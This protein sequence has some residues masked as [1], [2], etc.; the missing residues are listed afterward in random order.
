M[1]MGGLMSWTVETRM[2]DFDQKIVVVLPQEYHEG[3]EGV[4]TLGL[5][6]TSAVPE[7]PYEELLSLV[8]NTPETRSWVLMTDY[9]LIRELF[10]VDLPGPE[11]D[12]DQLKEFLIALSEA[13]DNAMPQG[14]FISGFKS[15]FETVSRDYLGF[16]VRNV[17]QSVEAGQPPGV[18][19]AVR[20]RFDPEGTDRALR[21]CAECPPPDRTSHLG[22]AFYSWG[23]DYHV[24]LRR[25][26]EPPAF[27]R[28]GRGGRIAVQEGYV[29][30]TLATDDMK[31]LI[32]ASLGRWRSLGDL[33]ELRL[34]ARA[35]ASLG[36][37]STLLTDLT[38]RLEEAATMGL[39][40]EALRSLRESPS[41]RP[42]LAFATGVGQDAGG[43]YMALA[44]VHVDAASAEQNVGLLRRRIEEAT[45]LRFPGTPWAEIFDADSLEV[46]SDGR[47]LVAKLRRT[48]GRMGTSWLQ[49]VMARDPLLL[50]E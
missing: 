6:V 25:I 46:S 40:D 26:L 12:E 14:P 19:E 8:P 42:Y 22:V 15:I 32:E 4:P 18:L 24:D 29:F 7:T 1:T 9:A 21:E 34:L 5:T 10:D 36:A 35:M 28:L 17:D 50:H 43:A 41:L 13:T 20:G 2:Y 3:L 47:V 11:V 31:A 45:S 33:E 27:D 44:L 38:Q 30:R 48:G 39:D 37:Y 23:E 16:D 49:F